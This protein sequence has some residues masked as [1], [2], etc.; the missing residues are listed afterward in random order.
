VLPQYPIGLWNQYDATIGGF[1][2][3]NNLSKGW[4]NRLNL[5]TGRAHPDLYSFLKVIRKEQQEVDT[6]L[7]KVGLGRSVRPAKKK[8]YAALELRVKAIVDCY[9]AYKEDNKILDYLVNL[10]WNITFA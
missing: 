7:V 3:T 5:L 1:Q 9:T 6:I 2:R 4:H 8:R 10:G